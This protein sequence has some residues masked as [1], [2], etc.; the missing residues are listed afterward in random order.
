MSDV[1]SPTE[2]R[3][4]LHLFCRASKG[5]ER[6]RLIRAVD[7]ARSQGAQVVP[8]AILGHKADFALM[9]DTADM[10]QMRR[11]Q[12][13]VVGAR[14][15]VADSF[16][17]LTEVSEYAQNRPD[18]YKQAKLYP[19]LPPEGLTNWCFYGMS[20]TRDVGA[21]WYLLDLAERKRLMGEHGG[22]GRAYRGR[23]LQLITG[24]S[25]LD[26]FEW[27]VTLFA[28]HPDDLKQIVYEMRY[29]RASAEFGIFGPFFTGVI[30]SLEQVLDAATP[31]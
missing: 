25:G 12:S 26:D 5:L 17:S 2:G 27:G 23:V 24:S 30:G 10:W 16:V 15:E 11:F 31:G 7:D 6:D 13:A 14:V 8:V 9:V 20:R 1:A 21:N 4:V 18:E 29:D 19:S 22:T 3:V 28:K